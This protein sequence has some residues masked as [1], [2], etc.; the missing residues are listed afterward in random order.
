M[1]T[2]LWMAIKD[3]KNKMQTEKFNQFPVSYPLNVII[4]ALG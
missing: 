2:I 4:V 1:K 3:Y